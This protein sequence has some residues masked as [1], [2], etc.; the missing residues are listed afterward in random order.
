LIDASAN[1]ISDTGVC[2]FHGVLLS[3]HTPPMRT[4]WLKDEQVAAE[5]IKRSV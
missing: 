4:G 1:R 2:F 3:R 5:G